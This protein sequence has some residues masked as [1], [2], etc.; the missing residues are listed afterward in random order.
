MSEENTQLHG[1]EE[2]GLNNANA[3]ENESNNV[4]NENEEPIIILEDEI[5][6]DNKAAFN[7][8]Y[9]EMDSESN[10]KKEHKVLKTVA[11]VAACAVL[12]G[13]IAGGSSAITN[14]YINSKI[15]ISSTQNVLTRSDSGNPD[16]D[17]SDSLIADI[18]EECMPSIVSITNKS[19]TEVMTFFGR[20]AQENVSS[21]SGIIIGKNDSELLIVTNYHVIADSQELSVIFSDTNVTAGTLTEE[22]AEDNGTGVT[23]DAKDADVLKAKVKGYDS[24]KDLAVISIP[25]DSISAD[26]MSKIKVATIGDSSTLRPGDGV[27][28]IGNALGYGK[29]VTTGIVSATNREV[30]LDSQTAAG[31]KVTNKFIQTDAAINQGNSGGALLNK[32]G[33]LIGINSVKIVSSG[34]E[35]MG[36]AIPITDVGSIIDEL[37]I[38]ETREVV[39]EDKQGF[40]GITFENVTSEISEA[41]GMPA[42][43]YVK[44]VSEGSAADKAGIKKGY[45]ITKFDNYT[46]KSGA[47]LQNRLSFYKAGEKKTITVQIHGEDGYEEKELTVT[48]DSKKDGTK[49]MENETNE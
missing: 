27:I 19:V 33:E 37:M 4:G 14:K 31:Q 35:G 39:D 25:L 30:T 36:Y 18:A 45:I 43:V 49:K 46:V 12:F 16:S 13:V 44:S 3:S 28:A 34:V 8:Q 32:K 1:Y 47:E 38:R 6:E 5:P 9:Q 41:Y 7:G 15:K 24:D 20:Y 26:L 10:A 40:L 17:M 2:E 29:S 22:S 23:E 48:L 21:G 42:G 11:A